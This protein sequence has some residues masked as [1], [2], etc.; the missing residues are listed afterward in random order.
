MSLYTVYFLRKTSTLAKIK[1]TRAYLILRLFVYVNIKYFRLT[2]K[3]PL[4]FY[5]N[6]SHYFNDNPFFKQYLI[7]KSLI[8]I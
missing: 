2:L 1:K 5:F 4:L 6:V 7:I 8:L 3:N